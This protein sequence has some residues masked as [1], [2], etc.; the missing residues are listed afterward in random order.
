MVT[1]PGIT[2]VSNLDTPL[3]F[4]YIKHTEYLGFVMS[5]PKPISTK[6]H[7]YQH[8]YWVALP[9]K[10]K[11]DRRLDLVLTLLEFESWL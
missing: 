7:S 2:R 8:I 1:T 3:N 6:T 10:V 11:A 4:L 9:T 5:Q